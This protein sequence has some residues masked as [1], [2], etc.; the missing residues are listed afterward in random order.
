[1]N[2]RHEVNVCADARHGEL[3]GRFVREVR[4]QH[5]DPLIAQESAQ[6][7][8][9]AW[10]VR[11]EARNP[12]HAG[13]GRHDRAEVQPKRRKADPAGDFLD[14]ITLAGK[15]EVHPVT[16]VAQ[17][18]GNGVHD[19]ADTTDVVPGNG[20][21]NVH[22]P[23]RRRGEKRHPDRQVVSGVVAMASIGQCTII[24]IRF[25]SR[26]GCAIRL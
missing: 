25:G 18:E 2:G 7:P 24:G 4:I 8:L 1:V 22:M 16:A 12:A 14:P 5:V 19:V 15:E 10:E 13:T 17:V 21:Q 11:E 3:N 23:T 6:P 9:G 20:H 26:N